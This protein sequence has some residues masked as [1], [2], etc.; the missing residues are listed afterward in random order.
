MGRKD[1]DY[2]HASARTSYL[3]NK[4]VT[5]SQLMR[6]AGA[7]SVQEA[8]NILSSNSVF[9]DRKWEDYRTTLEK[10]L[11]DTYT[12]IEDITGNIGLTHVFRYH[13]DGHNMKVIVKSRQTGEDRSDLY[14]SGG[15]V[16]V[17][18]ME[19]AIG[20]KHLDSVN[21]VLAEAGAEAV[22]RFAQTGDP[23]TVDLIIDAAVMKM[24][25]G[26][27]LKLGDPLLI[28]YVMTQIDMINIA[29]ALRLM[30]ADADGRMAEKVFSDEGSFSRSEFKKAFS[31]GYDGIR[32]L[33]KK[34]DYGEAVSK[35]IENTE[36]VI[37]FE[38]MKEN[39]MSELFYRMRVWAFGTGPVISFLYFKEREIRGCRFVLA[40]K[41]FNVSVKEIERGLSGIYGS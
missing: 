38:I 29:T 3:E 33:V 35:P 25:K 26:K 17:S 16:S 28:E 27:A 19:E 22:K 4:M 34:L 41:E 12:L 10:D 23:Q 24:M 15:T 9:K 21:R 37:F 31:E 6:A 2:L 13:I 8:Y 39:I 5:E 40:S 20:G 1:T 32:K 14:K 7:G 36:D 30:R 18:N 11:T